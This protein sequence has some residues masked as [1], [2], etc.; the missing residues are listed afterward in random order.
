[1]KNIECKK[2]S[3]LAIQMFHFVTENREV[4]LKASCIQWKSSQWPKRVKNE[5]KFTGSKIGA[6]FCKIASRI[7]TK[8]F[9]IGPWALSEKLAFLF[10]ASPKACQLEVRAKRALD[11]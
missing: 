7:T 5:K 11:F 3:L 6:I 10:F 2:S 9:K 1:M 8:K 4:Q